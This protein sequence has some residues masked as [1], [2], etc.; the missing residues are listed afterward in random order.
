MWLW[1]VWCV[2]TSS[3]DRGIAERRTST[4]RQRAA[5]ERERARCGVKSRR[6]GMY[7]R[8]A[9]GVVRRVDDRAAGSNNRPTGA[10]EDASYVVSPAHPSLVLVV[11]TLLQAPRRDGAWF[12]ANHMA[13]A[14][15]FEGYE[16]YVHVA[17]DVRMGL[18][19][20]LEE[21]PHDTCVL[22]PVPTLLPVAVPI[23]AVAGNAAARVAVHRCVLHGI[24]M[25]H[26]VHKAI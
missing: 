16:G 9:R 11:Q 21:A 12:A 23:A 24:R 13:T 25:I 19:Q 3:L 6:I 18:C 15:P 7:G 8:V 20:Y 5:S 26:V 4:T 17:C 2:R 22:V 14:L 1:G 10:V